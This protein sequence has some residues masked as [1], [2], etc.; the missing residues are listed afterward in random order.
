MVMSGL[1]V[2]TDR[3]DGKVEG[4]DWQKILVQFNCLVAE[5]NKVV[6]VISALTCLKP[7]N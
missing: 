4:D 6:S 7:V 3:Y 5:A 2:C 1:V